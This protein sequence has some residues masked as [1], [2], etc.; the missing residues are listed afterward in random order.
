MT[1]ASLPQE[2]G[3]AAG[4]RSVVQRVFGEPRFH[5]AGDL[6]DLTFAPEGAVWSIDE[7]GLLR[8]WDPSTGQDV[9]QYVVSDLE[10]L[11][12]FSG[13]ARLLVSASDDLTLWDVASGQV[14][15]TVPQDSWVT[16]AA[17]GSAKVRAGDAPLLAT[18]HDDGKVRL[19]D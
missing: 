14:R 7:P 18:G 2:A 10:T 13:D 6:L 3:A 8:Q 12:V 19:W 15:S 16:T 4:S 17:F 11:W 5:T 9:Q 1:S